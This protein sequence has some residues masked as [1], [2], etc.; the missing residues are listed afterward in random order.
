[1]AGWRNQPFVC[2]GARDEEQLCS[3]PHAAPTCGGAS[4]PDVLQMCERQS[5]LERDSPPPRWGA[6]ISC[7]PSATSSSGESLLRGFAMCQSGQVSVP[8]PTDG[9]CVKSWGVSKH[10]GRFFDP[11]LWS[12]APVAP[13]F[14]HRNQQTVRDE[15]CGARTELSK[16]R[17][18]PPFT[19]RAQAGSSETR[20]E[21]VGFQNKIPE[22]YETISV[23]SEVLF[24]FILFILL[25]KGR[26]SYFQSLPRSLTELYELIITVSPCSRAWWLLCGS[27]SFLH[28]PKE[29]PTGGWVNRFPSA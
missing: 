8:P 9:V 7:T 10:A 19:Q 17:T 21:S 5:K 22:A 23:N 15:E 1:M 6:C 24:Y 14:V 13:G 26:W 12:P 16:S 20:S 3:S 28:H 11:G 27:S 4:Q 29:A 2:W 25:F 18:S